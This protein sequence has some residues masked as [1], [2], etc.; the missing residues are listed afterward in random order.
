M[1]DRQAQLDLPVFQTVYVTKTHIFST[2]FAY[3]VPNMP[4]LQSHP[5]ALHN[6]VARPICSCR[7]GK[8]VFYYICLVS[9]K[10]ML[11]VYYLPVLATPVLLAVIPQQDQQHASVTPEPAGMVLAAIPVLKTTLDHQISWVLE[12]QGVLH[13]LRMLLR[14]MQVLLRSASV[15]VRLGISVMD[16]LDVLLVLKVS[17]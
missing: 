12:M 16:V 6:V 11:I 4:L 9:K 17:T 7:M 15:N 13:V 2:A 5:R 1:Q 3:N 10:F 14:T 8:L